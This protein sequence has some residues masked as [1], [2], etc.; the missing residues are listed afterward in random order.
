[1]TGSDVQR[2]GRGSR[3]PTEESTATGIYGII[4]SAAVMAASH[5]ESA[6]AV[7]VSVLITLLIYWS[8]ERYSRLVAERIHD[9]RRPTWRQVRG[10][11]T[12]GWEFVTASALPLAVL[13]VLRLMGADLKA[14]VL[15]GLVCSTALLCLAGWK[16]GSSGHL[17]WVERLLTT[18]VAGLFGIGLIVLKAALH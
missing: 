10:Q 17:A 6:T 2:T 9:A 13:V 4:V 12:T 16:I 18:A 11:L 7:V 5:A 14:A 8:A 1:M 15:G 3:R